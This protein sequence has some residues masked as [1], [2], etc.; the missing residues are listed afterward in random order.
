MFFFGDEEVTLNHLEYDALISLELTCP[1][2]IPKKLGPKESDEENTTRLE[3]SHMWGVFHHEDEI[4]VF[5]G[6]SD[7][8]DESTLIEGELFFFEIIPEMLFCK[9]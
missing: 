6:P 9:V 1:S 5:I 2:N 8:K 7:W 3:V 4:I